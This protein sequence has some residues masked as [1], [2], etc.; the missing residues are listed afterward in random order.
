MDTG[1]KDSELIIIEL[2]WLSLLSSSLCTSHCIIL[3]KT[4]TVLYNDIRVVISGICKF[5]GL[6]AKI[7][8]LSVLPAYL[9]L[10]LDAG[11]VLVL[12]HR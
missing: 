7:K 11:T 10:V 6:L 1:R 5:L 9:P 4:S 3:S 12:F 8:V 2:H